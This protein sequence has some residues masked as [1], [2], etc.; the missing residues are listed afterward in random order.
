[1]VRN[2]ALIFSRIYL[3]SVYINRG[4]SPLRNVQG[5]AVDRYFGLAAGTGNCC[6]GGGAG[7]S[8]DAVGRSGPAAVQSS[9]LQ[10]QRATLQNV[11]ISID[12][13]R[14]RKAQTPSSQR[15]SGSH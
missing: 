15:S 4:G 11:E 1:M 9:P 8:G 5:K 6:S 3:Q 12:G 14:C 13:C 2:A 10:L 7:G